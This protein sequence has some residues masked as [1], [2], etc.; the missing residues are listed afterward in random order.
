MIWVDMPLSL[1]VQEMGLP[2]A[3]VSAV[4]GAGNVRHEWAVDLQE[5]RLRR[6]ERRW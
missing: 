2:P 1:V 4:D 6:S 3:P 5:Q